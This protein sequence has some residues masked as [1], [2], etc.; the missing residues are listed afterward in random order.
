MNTRF[1]LTV[2]GETSSDQKKT[3]IVDNTVLNI[4]LNTLAQINA[5]LTKRKNLNYKTKPKKSTPFVYQ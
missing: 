3:Y 1:K 2:Y 5:Q 4:D